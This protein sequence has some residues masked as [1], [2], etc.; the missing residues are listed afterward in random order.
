M[1][2]PSKWFASVW[3]LMPFPFP[4]FPHTLQMSAFL[5]LLFEQKFRLFV[6]DFTLSSNS[7]K[8]VSPWFEFWKLK[9]FFQFG[10]RSISWDSWITLSSDITTAS[11]FPPI[12][13]GVCFLKNIGLSTIQEIN[14]R[15]EVIKLYPF[16]RRLPGWPCKPPSA[17][18]SKWFQ[19]IDFGCNRTCSYSSLNTVSLC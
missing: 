19:S 6:I 7:C 14:Y 3:S 17:T 16:Q 13:L 12:I 9:H 2:S 8:L 4:S 15:S 1:L 11:V 5:P 18:I 10:Q